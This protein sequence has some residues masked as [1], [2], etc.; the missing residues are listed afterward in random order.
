[1]LWGLGIQAR[2][3]PRF[4][5]GRRDCHIRQNTDC[6]IRLKEPAAAV[7]R[8]LAYAGIFN[9]PLRREEISKYLILDSAIRI[10]EAGIYNAIHRITTDR[11]GLIGEKE[12]YY[13]LEGFEGGVKQRKRRRK[14]AKGKYKVAGR[15]VRWA[16]LIPTVK[17]V[18]VSGALAVDNA[19]EED[20]IDLFIIAQAG[21]VWITRFLSVLLA[22]ILR[23][24]RCPSGTDIKDKICLN[25]FV[26]EK[27]MGVAEN[28]RDLFSA[29]EVVQ[30]RPIYDRG[31]VYN[32]FI[33]MNRWVREYLPNA[34][35][36][37][38]TA[39]Q[40]LKPRLPFA[41]NI[42][43][44][45][46]GFLKKIQLFYMRPKITQEVVAD[47]YLRFHPVDARRVVLRRY[48][49]VLKNA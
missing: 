35:G 9:Y 26:D 27:H 49:E 31:G 20:D 1:M 16:K 25:M 41:G 48:K 39:T 13:F 22:E 45:V 11:K 8:T 15:F 19:H 3:E 14:I 7:L 23:V 46:E 42:I 38:K 32:R 40:N 30:M 12:G 33:Y 10:Q 2:G 44:L 17:L 36:Q 24:R 37:L 29:H 47:G 28:E 18:G 6:K 34:I 43:A 4:A 5:V 21:T